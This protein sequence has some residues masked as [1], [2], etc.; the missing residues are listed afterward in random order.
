[1]IEAQA[2]KLLA[3]QDKS[4]NES[5]PMDVDN[6]DP[7][8]NKQSISSDVEMKEPS[9]SKSEENLEEKNEKKS[10]SDDLIDIDPKTYC[11]LAHFHL[12]LGDFAKGMQIFPN[13]LHS[14]S[15]CTIFH[16]T[17]GLSKI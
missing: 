14:L 9:E 13:E 8:V 10:E 11:K 2:R 5:S 1:L 15:N 4:K 16:S 3:E 7:A 17:I 12:L 6:Q